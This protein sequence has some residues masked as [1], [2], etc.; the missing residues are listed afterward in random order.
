MIFRLGAGLSGGA[1]DV[2]AVLDTADEERV[3]VVEDTEGDA[4]VTSPG[5]APASEL[6]PQRFRDP[7]RVGGQCRGNELGDG[8]RDLVRKPIKRPHGTGRQSD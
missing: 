5:D 1:V 4:V 3:V 6:V 7:V 8:G 2:R